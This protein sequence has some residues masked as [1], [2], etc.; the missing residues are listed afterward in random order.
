MFRVSSLELDLT[1]MSPI[2]IIL[3][4]VVCNGLFPYCGISVH[5][6]ITSYLKIGGEPIYKLLR[7]LN[8]TEH[9]LI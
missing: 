1:D 7:Q 8:T 3:C 9:C 5:I 6:I 4:P 2:L